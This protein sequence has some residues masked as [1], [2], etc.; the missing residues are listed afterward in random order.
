M[1]MSYGV[2]MMR[3]IIVCGYMIR[4]PVA[5]NL[6]AYFHYVLGLHRLGYK[7]V[8]LEE[9]GGPSPATTHSPTITVTIHKRDCVQRR[10]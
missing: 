6:L 5:G 8:Y 3:C 9:S 10:H 7:V 2:V 1:G 4:H